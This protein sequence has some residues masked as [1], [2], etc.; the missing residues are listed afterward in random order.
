MTRNERK[1]AEPVEATHAPSRRQRC[2]E[3]RALHAPSVSV[4]SS[5][6]ASFAS[7]TPAATAST[8]RRGGSRRTQSPVPGAVT[9]HPRLQAWAREIDAKEGTVLFRAGQAAE[10]VFLLLSGEVALQ[11]TTCAG[12]VVTM[13]QY[14]PGQVMA[15]ASLSSGRHRLD[16]V[17]TRASR[18]LVLPMAK[19]R[20]E[21]NNDPEVRWSWIASGTGASDDCVLKAYRL[22][23]WRVEERLRHLIL[24]TGDETQTLHWPGSQTALAEELGLTRFALCRV[25]GRLVAEQ[26]LESNDDTI[27]WIGE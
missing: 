27:R 18:L 13:G 16:G 21:I 24:S 3:R 14:R 4:L 5:A 7:T 2:E 25:L 17:C 6:T 20:E 12:T 10:S 1:R 8:A 15:A 19:W 11:T 22:T 26:R 23:L 9:L